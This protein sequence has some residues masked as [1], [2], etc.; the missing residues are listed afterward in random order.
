M[1]PLTPKIPEKKV[2]EMEEEKEKKRLGEITVSNSVRGYKK[3]K[4]H[5]MTRMSWRVS[6]DAFCQLATVDLKFISEESKKKSW[7][8][9]PMPVL[10]GQF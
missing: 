1:T 3:A 7:E 2:R 5:L 8:V 4:K 10:V 9:G 6:K